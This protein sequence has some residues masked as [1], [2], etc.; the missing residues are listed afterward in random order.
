MLSVETRPY[1]HGSDRPAAIR[2]AASRRDPMAKLVLVGG[3]DIA[4]MALFSVEALPAQ[5]PEPE[6]L[7]AL[8]EDG[9]LLRIPTGAD[10]AYLL[11]AYVDEPI[12]GELMRYCSATESIRGRL[13]LPH[14]RLGF[15][16]SESAFAGF[17]P[18]EAIRSDG[19]VAPGEYGITAYRTKFPDDL[20]ATVVAASFGKHDMR[21]LA[22]PVQI[23]VA[24]LA[25]IVPALLVELWLAAAV[26]ALLAAGGI[27]MY[28]KHP[29]TEQLREQ[30][31]R[32]ELEY[33]SIVITM[34]SREG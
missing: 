32:V 13:R 28:L 6:A 34:R 17:V 10:G 33:P 18:N 12:P 23:V 27:R 29:T 26:I 1:R 9:Q 19:E 14:G 11:H 4:E 15:G 24:A 3:T 25:L 30:R 8:A 2:V 31:R 16:G 22:I 7:D 21:H 5:R 20:I